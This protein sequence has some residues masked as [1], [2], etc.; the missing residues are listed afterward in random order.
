M[1]RQ[2]IDA[3]MARLGLNVPEKERDDLAAASKYAEDMARRVG[4]P[5]PAGAEPLN[6]PAF[7]STAVG[8]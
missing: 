1:T 3:L 5:R 6:T 7:P 4:K 8:G 2:E